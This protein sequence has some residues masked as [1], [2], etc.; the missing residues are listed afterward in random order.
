M[1]LM[2]PR[3]Y[4]G[5]AGFERNVTCQNKENF[6]QKVRQVELHQ[7]RPAKSANADIHSK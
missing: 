3:I 7:A 6:L 1:K 4:G 2:F 5:V